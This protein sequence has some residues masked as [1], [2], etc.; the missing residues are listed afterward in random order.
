[1][2]VGAFPAPPIPGITPVR[3][4]AINTTTGPLAVPAP[5]GQTPGF[6]VCLTNGAIICDAMPPF[7]VMPSLFA[8]PT[9]CRGLAISNDPVLLQ[10]L[11]NGFDY[12]FNNDP[13]Y[14]PYYPQIGL[15]APACKFLSTTCSLTLDGGPASS[16]V[17]LTADLAPLA[18]SGG[19]VIVG[20]NVLWLN[21]FSP[22]LLLVPFPTDGAGHAEIT[23]PLSFPPMGF[24]VMAQWLFPDS[25]A[26]LGDRFTDALLVHVGLR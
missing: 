13:R 25:G 21:P 15:T 20:G 12:I 3:G 11:H 9:Y 8:F 26:Y 6:R 24:Q 19:G 2:L 18:P 10:G 16:A 14:S 4:V 1:M 17:L 7:G 23:L 22:T 5:P